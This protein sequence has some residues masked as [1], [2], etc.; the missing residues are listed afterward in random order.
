M[1]YKIRFPWKIFCITFFIIQIIQY[2]FNIDVLRIYT[3]V[4]N[5]LCYSLGSTVIP[6]VLACLLDYLY[7]R[8]TRKKSYESDYNIINSSYGLGNLREE[9]DD[10]KCFWILVISNSAGIRNNDGVSYTG[11]ICFDFSNQSVENL[12][13]KE[14]ILRKI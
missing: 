6:I 13:K 10:V 4:D 12:Y 11:Y 5:G 3:P 2:G 14:F 1:K 8:H 7:Q 9:K